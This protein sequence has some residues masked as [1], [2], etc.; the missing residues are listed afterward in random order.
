MVRQTVRLVRKLLIHN[1][2][3]D[4]HSL[5][6]DSFASQRRFVPIYRA[7]GQRVLRTTA[8]PEAVYDLLTGRRLFFTDPI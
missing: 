3:G 5:C 8:S 2:F 6:I 7:P 1:D 4:W